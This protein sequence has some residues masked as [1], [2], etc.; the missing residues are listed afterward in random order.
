MGYQGF[1]YRGRVIFV[2]GQLQPGFRVLLKP[3][4]GFKPLGNYYDVVLRIIMAQ[5]DG[6]IRLRPRAYVG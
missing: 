5:E 1:S 3:F 4:L 6:D 2:M